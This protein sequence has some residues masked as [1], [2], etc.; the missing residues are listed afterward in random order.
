M[1]ISDKYIKMKE[2]RFN[3]NMKFAEAGV[4]FDDPDTAY[5]D[6]SVTIGRGTIIGPSV[7]IKGNTKIGE[8]CRLD[9]NSHIEDTEIGDGTRIYMSVAVD[10]KIGKD[11][12]IGP[13]ANLRPKSDIADNVRIGD[14]VEIKN[15]VIGEGT[16]ISHLTYVGDAD[17]GS[18]IN[19]GCGVVFVNFD[20]KV[21]HRSTVGDGAFIG[22]NANIIAPV[23]IEDGAYIAA[24]TTV[25][26][27][28]TEA[29]LC[30]GRSRE[31]IVED[32]ARDR[33]FVGK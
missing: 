33:G 30:V 16:K 19:L 9:Q 1:V 26:R 22:C 25:T 23:V 29:S 32:W 8:N 5:I 31:I 15:S 11:C 18:G 20:G 27:N 3:L 12:S 28:V 4:I 17:L 13:F 10:S 21:K 7:V 14:F 6:E 2:D 24:G